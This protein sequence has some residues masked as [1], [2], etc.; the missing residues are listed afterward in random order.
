[1]NVDLY[2]ELDNLF[3]KSEE[4]MIALNEI[5]AVNNNENFKA[6]IAWV[7]LLYALKFSLETTNSLRLA[8][9]AIE[10]NK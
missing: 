8:M 3:N 2:E 5:T 4:I 10:N 1:M 9:R 6:T 7:N